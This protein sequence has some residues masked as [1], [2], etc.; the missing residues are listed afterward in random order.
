MKLNN[1]KSTWQL[2][3]VVSVL[4]LTLVMAASCSDSGSGNSEDGDNPIINCIT[5]ADCPALYSCNV[6]DGVCGT[7]ANAT[8]CYDVTECSTGYCCYVATDSADNLGKCVPEDGSVSCDIPGDGDTGD[9]DE[10]IPDTCKEDSD[11]NDPNYVC[12]DNAC[13]ERN[14]YCDNIRDCLN[15]QRCEDGVCTGEPVCGEDGDVDTADPDVD[16][17]D[18]DVDPDP[19][20]DPD[21]A[22]GC[23]RSTDCPEGM[24]CGPGG[25][26]GPRCDATGQSCPEGQTC[27]PN[28]GLCE[29]CENDCETGRC[30]NRSQ[31]FWY[32]G[33]CCTP[34]CA[35][36]Q[37]CQ[38]GTCVA[39]A[40][41]E[42]D[43]GETCDEGTACKV[44]ESEPVDGDTDG[45][46]DACLPANSACQEGVD[47]CCSGTCMMGTC[48]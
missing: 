37:A 41:P 30:C 22:G 39:L 7:D 34:P 32:C 4:L 46:K 2:F 1:S 19:D 27:N 40:C 47:N 33:Q 3:S 36:G 45:T 13:E 6:T 29:C 48:L 12:C 38:A 26:C 5:H 44:C 15:G 16:A 11:C 10:G 17:V 23:E 18:G 14:R 20:P 31:G 21:N 42:C 25:V 35:D 9:G 24:I 43:S 28:N 8:P